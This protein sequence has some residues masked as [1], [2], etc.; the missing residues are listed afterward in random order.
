MT[1][2]VLKSSVFRRPHEYAT[3]SFSKI[4]TLESV[5]EKLLFRSSFSYY[6][7]YIRV[8]DNRIRNKSLQFMLNPQAVV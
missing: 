2:S 8:Y 7:Q 5:F 1:S 4:S 6:T 3:A